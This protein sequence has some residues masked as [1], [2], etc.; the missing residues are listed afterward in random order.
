MKFNA[1][2]G[3]LTS[4]LFSVALFSSCTKNVSEEI[5]LR[6]SPDLEEIP[7]A[8]GPS[9]SPCSINSIEIKDGFGNY[10]RTLSFSYNTDGNPVSVLN[11]NVG[12]GAPN[13]FFN[14][15][16]D[17][18]LVEWIGLY[19]NGLYES[20][21]RY[22]YDAE[23]RIIKDTQWVFGTYGPDPDP[24]SFYIREYTY[25]YDNKG[26]IITKTTVDLK[27]D[28]PDE[29]TVY[30]YQGGNLDDGSTYDNK[31]NMGRTNLLWL[32]LNQD[33]S[34]NN[35]VP[36]VTYNSNKLPLEFN[37]SDAFTFLGYNIERSEVSY[38]CP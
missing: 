14:Y 21:H 8:A 11:D 7:S 37:S 15:D 1:P 20:W 26:R 16:T 9:L 27:E 22:G 25:E 19:L 23:N 10:E 38:S 3:S 36:A 28:Y 34:K 35:Q 6:P 31:I 5:S 13:Y 29:V 32:F 18:R 33:Y 2:I 12:T 17:D 24:N 30:S 4:L